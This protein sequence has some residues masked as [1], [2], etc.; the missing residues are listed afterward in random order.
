MTRPTSQY[1]E[2]TAR[3]EAYE[4]GKRCGE[5]FINLCKLLPNLVCCEANFKILMDYFL[6]DHLLFDRLA[7]REAIENDASLR[8]RLAWRTKEEIEEHNEEVIKQH[9]DALIAKPISELHEE[10]KEKQ[11]QREES[12]KRKVPA[13]IT[14]KAFIKASPA[15]AREW[16]DKWTLRVLNEHWAQQDREAGNV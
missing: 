12:W 9:N 1:K 11:K 2:L 16:A 10:L 8:K 13:E 6:P 4:D 5:E 14:R 3:L 15:Q 7:G